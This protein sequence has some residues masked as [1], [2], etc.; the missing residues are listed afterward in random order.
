MSRLAGGQSMQEIQG[1]AKLECINVLI[2]AL[3]QDIGMKSM[4]FGSGLQRAGCD[5]RHWYTESREPMGGATLS[6]RGV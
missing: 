6:W 5:A 4:G 1:E 3:I 2:P